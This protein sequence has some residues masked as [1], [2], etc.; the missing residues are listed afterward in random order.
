MRKVE[1]PI[2]IVTF[3]AA[4]KITGIKKVLVV[5]NDIFSNF[6]AEDVSQVVMEIAK[7][8]SHILAPSSNHGKNYLPRVAALMDSSPLTDVLGVVNESTFQR[9]GF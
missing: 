9:V 1:Q 2:I 7:D 4:A 5:D 6:I 3:Q 8:F